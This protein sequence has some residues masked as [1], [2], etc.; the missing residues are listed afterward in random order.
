MLRVYQSTSAAQA[1]NY[2]SNELIKGDYYTEGQE[3]AGMWGGKAADMLGLSGTVGQAEFNAL[4]DNAYPDTSPSAGE[5]ITP[6]NKSNRRP[7]YDLTFNAPKALSLL[8]EYSQDE[9][10]LDAFR[11]AVKNTMGSIEEA[12][13]TRVRK[14]GKNEDRQTGNLAYAEFVHF[15]A[16]PVEA[17]APDP[18]LHAHCYAMNLTYDQVE[19]QWKA[20]E[21]SAIKS[22]APYY[23]ALFHSHLTKSLADMGL[24]IVKDGKFWSIDGL[25]KDT[26]AKFSNRA[27]QIEEAARERGI[28]TDKGRDSLAQ[29][30]RSGK[31]G[32]LTRDALRE[33]WWD[34]LD[35]SERATLDDLNKFDPG[36]SEPPMFTPEESVEYAINH[37][38]ERQSVS[39]VNR[40]KE[41]AL[42]HAF[43]SVS[44]AEI[45]AEFAA[46]DDLIVVG[47]RATTEEI[48]SQEKQIV[49]YTLDGYAMHD[50]LNADYEIEAVTDY[51][52]G[53]QF[54]LGNDQKN[55]I[56]NLL[57]SR[58]RV[59]AV[60][61]KAGTGK[62][63][64]LATLVDGIEQGGGSA[65]MLA[66]T[67][68]A[69]YDTLKKD[70]EDYRSHALQNAHTLARYFVDEKLWESSRGNTL[71][72]DEAGLMS[73]KDMHT[74]FALANQ[75]D[76][77]VILVGDTSQHN[78]VLRG[79]AFRIL[80]NE[81][82]LEPLNLDAIRRQSGKY[83]QAVNAI[84]RGKLV[85]GYD[86]LDKLGT[87]TEEEDDEARY[88]LLAD[89]YADA[90][91]KGNKTLTVAPTHAEGE[92]VTNA[93]RDTLKERGE[94]QKN[95]SSTI[96]YRN[97]QL[98]E[99]ERGDQRNFERGQLVRF[100]QNGK[101]RNGKRINRGEQFTVSRVGRKNVWVKDRKGKEQAL[102]LSQAKRFNIYDKR[103]LKLA[104][105]DRIR[106]TE[107]HKSKDGRR[108]NN[109]AIYKVKRVAEN[110]DVTL[111]NKAVLDA[112][113]GNVD[114]GYVTT[115]YA[116]QGKTVHNVF[117]AQGTEYGGASSAE[118]F[119][120]S[121]SRGK[122]SVEIF[123][124]DKSLLR[125]QIQRSHQRQSAI[126][127]VQ[128]T[129]EKRA[130]DPTTRDSF[131]ATMEFY[132]RQFM[133]HMRKSAMD[134]LMQFRRPDGGGP[135]EHTRWR[136]MVARQQAEERNRELTL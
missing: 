16:R 39:S 122:Q 48:L 130:D 35:T 52:T 50:K 82:Q 10:L 94:L 71:I 72:V 103:E 83:K 129:Q 127:M 7:G 128:E 55:V 106:I 124:D 31:V 17:M 84:S 107:G 4:V 9:R 11:E 117:I 21:F 8:Y 133:E 100:K 78:S 69:A 123:T 110:G 40:L 13:H 108:L 15:T 97:L 30:T 49:R 66:P 43:G 63:T 114:Y 92:K 26:L 85:E 105:G 89:H 27:E 23:E 51:R 41:S 121:V 91:Q 34:R 62:T 38:L 65:M 42:R 54:E 81:A 57:N 56:E 73:V 96:Q 25:E 88:R 3:I 20:G 134:W 104:S 36:G 74:L 60:H 131:V 135:S 75:F 37:R 22:D 136:E 87:I 12:M 19:D 2:F 115:S 45:D 33:T 61:G 112:N 116:S 58:D 77:R 76:N 113:A 6:H 28:K 118:Q 95:E 125:D 32:G 64:A 59:M 29:N 5:R 79:D 101:G 14:D 46:N 102:D 98:T 24:D 86:M 132:A 68:D 80:Q 126:E 93:I 70:G 111:S 53:K 90:V 18:H 1:K 67:A 109:G 119:Y 120:V 47:D 44:P 99:A